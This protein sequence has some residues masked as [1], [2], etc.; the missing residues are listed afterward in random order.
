MDIN[1]LT[2]PQDVNFISNSNNGFHPNQ[3]FNAGRNKPSF[4]LDNRQ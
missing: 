1:C 2:V 3:D 4:L